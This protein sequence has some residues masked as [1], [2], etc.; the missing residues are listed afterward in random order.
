M[1]LMYDYFLTLIRKSEI[2]FKCVV[3][4]N[5]KSQYNTNVLKS[6]TSMSHAMVR[7]CNVDI[8]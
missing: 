4:L 1:F 2:S 5:I 8:H 6:I 3:R 7:E